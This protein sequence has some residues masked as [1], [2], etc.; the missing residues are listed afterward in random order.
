MRSLFVDGLVVR[1]YIDV[2]MDI[3]I[4]IYAAPRQ[5]LLSVDAHLSLEALVVRVGGRGRRLHVCSGG[6]QVGDVDAR[7]RDVTA[8]EESQNKHRIEDTR[9]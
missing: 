9:G 5:L 3:Y 8:C 1:V 6:G 4:H 2:D 7:H